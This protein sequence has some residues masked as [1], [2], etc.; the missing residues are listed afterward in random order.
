MSTE[1]GTHWS[2][3]LEPQS[4]ETLFRRV[5]WSRVINHDRCVTSQLGVVTSYLQPT[6]PPVST[7]THAVAIPAVFSRCTHQL[8]AIPPNHTPPT[9]S[10]LTF[11]NITYLCAGATAGG[12]AAVY[13]ILGVV[14]ERRSKEDHHAG[15]VF[16][17]RLLPKLPFR[18]VEIS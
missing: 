6:S 16:F 12:S 7:T 13:G 1:G 10:S 17:G 14:K 3:K 2:C 11:P 5:S 18:W 9:P 4:W 8:P 15:A